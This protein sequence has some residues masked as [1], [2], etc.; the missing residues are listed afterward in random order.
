M[1]TAAITTPTRQEV[2]PPLQLTTTTV[3]LDDLCKVAQV[4]IDAMSFKELNDFVHLGVNCIALNQASIIRA[5]QVMKPAL[6]RIHEMCAG[7]GKRN[8]LAGG[9]TWKT[10]CANLYM[11]GCKRTLDELVKTAGLPNPTKQPKLLKGQKVILLADGTYVF[12]HWHICVITLGLMLVGALCNFAWWDG[13][14]TELDLG[15]LVV[16]LCSPFLFLFF[17]RRLPDYPHQNN[18]VLSFSNM[19]RASRDPHVW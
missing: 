8:D 5:R 18:N 13:M 17:E 15:I 10:Y 11:L 19:T 16:Y 7:Q 2:L 6:T 4:E 9:V 14:S 12:Q 3:T 1:T